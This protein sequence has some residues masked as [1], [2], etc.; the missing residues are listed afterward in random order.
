MNKTE[1]V[2]S[3]AEKTDI[4]KKEAEK[5]VTAVFESIE[6]ALGRGDKVQLVGFGTFEVRTREARKGRNPQTGE[7]IEIPATKVPAFKAGKALKDAVN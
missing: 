3:V 4:T 5:V 6:E 7:E 1:L 2:S